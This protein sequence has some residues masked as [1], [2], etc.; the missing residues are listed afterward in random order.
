M[1]KSNKLLTKNNFI[2]IMN[3]LARKRPIFH[4]EGDFLYSLGREI[5]I[6]YK[7]I[8]LRT[9]WRM[10]DIGHWIDLVLF[11]DYQDK[12]LIELKYISKKCEETINGELFDCRSQGGHPEGRYN[13]LKDIKKIENLKAKGFAIFLTNDEKYWDYS[14]YAGVIDK[15]FLL[16]E[17]YNFKKEVSYNW[18]SDCETYKN[19]GPIQFDYD[20]NI[21]WLSFGEQNSYNYRYLIIEI[22]NG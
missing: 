19:K 16:K 2:E 14:K 4:S 9:E 6:N 13:F 7:N 15:E 8:S 10:G 21:N 12:I 17:G 3:N 20:Y 22:G 1:T 18:K 11:N 5:E